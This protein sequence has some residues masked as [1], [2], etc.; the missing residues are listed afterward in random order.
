MITRDMYFRGRDKSYAG[1]FTVEIARNAS[2]LLERVNALLELAA[3]EGVTPGVDQ[4]TLN[5]VASGWR[6]AGV[7]ARTANAATASTHLLG[8]GIDIQDQH[9]GRPLARWCL[10]NLGQLERIGLWMEDPRW[11]GG[12]NNNDPWVHLQARP[13]RSGNRVYIPSS[14]PPGAPALPEQV[15]P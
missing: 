7:N 9:P 12:K 13:P 1:E 5:A 2:T 10:R 3:A 15:G 14:A 4:V 8:L 6:P 11:T